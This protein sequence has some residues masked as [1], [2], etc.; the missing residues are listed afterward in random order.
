[1]WFKYIKCMFYLNLL[2]RK[3]RFCINNVLLIWIKKIRNVSVLCARF[4]NVKLYDR[5]DS[6]I[7]VLHSYYH[8]RNISFLVSISH[9]DREESLMSA[10]IIYMHRF[11]F[12]FRQSYKGNWQT[13]IVIANSIEFDWGRRIGSRKRQRHDEWW[14]RYTK[15][16]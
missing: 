7:A 5:T 1:M 8:S 10:S 12:L 3:R 11:I 9:N 2:L 13:R 4:G 16:W 6:G 15:Y 14:N